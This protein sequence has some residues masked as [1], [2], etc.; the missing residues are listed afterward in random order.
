MRVGLIDADLFWGNRANGRRYGK[1]KA[2]IFPNLALMKLSAYH[3]QRGDDVSLY[4][5]FEQYDRV[6]ISKVFSTTPIERQVIF[7]NEVYFG[8]SGFCIE[9]VDG[10]EVYRHPE[11]NPFTGHLMYHTA[12]GIRTDPVKSGQKYIYTENLPYEIEHIMPDYS[13]YPTVKDTAYGFLTRGCPRGCHF[14]H[15][16]AKEGRRSYKVADLSDFHRKLDKAHQAQVFVLTNYDTTP[17]QDL[18]RIYTLRDMGFEPYVMVYDKT[19]AAPFYRSLQRWVNMRAIF[20]KIKTF[21]EYD[22]H[23]AKE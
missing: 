1:T 20:H 3:K 4:M 15:V 5:S 7:A 10:K 6:Y 12:P 2:D 17:A 13:L 14:C 16:E 23:K 19:H 8:G 22:R 18:E 11:H 21:E 9:L